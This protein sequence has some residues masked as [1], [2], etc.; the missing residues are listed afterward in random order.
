MDTTRH[1]ANG[2]SRSWLLALAATTVA[3]SWP[4]IQLVR[5][6]LARDLYSHVLLIPFVS[7]YFV[8]LLRSRLSSSGRPAYA[9]AMVAGLASL[10]LVAADLFTAHA[11]PLRADADALALTTGA[12]VCAVVAVTLWAL[13]SARARTLMFPL[14]FLVFMVPMPVWLTDRAETFLQYGSVAVASA[15]FSVAGT[16]V[17]HE[18][19]IFHLPGISLE[20]APECSGIHSTLALLITAVLASR[21]FLRTWTARATLVAL[22]VPLALLRNGF[23]VF[24]LGE[25]CV[26]IG[27]HMIDSPIHHKGGPIFFVLSLIPFVIVLR[28]LMRFET[29]RGVE[30]QP[31]HA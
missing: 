28:L 22:V 16:P 24:T 29:K 11:M 31:A 14:G 10:A 5:F 13:G 18:G 26:H 1:D 15:M 3:F 6:A 20:V 25:L 7:G 19:L 27:P 4:L 23:R 9:S 30:L 2:S 12:F 21:L 8:W 17:Y